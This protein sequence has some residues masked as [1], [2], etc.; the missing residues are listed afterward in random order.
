MDYVVLF[1]ILLIGL[2]RVVIV[3]ECIIF[4]KMVKEGMKKVGEKVSYYHNYKPK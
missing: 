4:C 2:K 1:Y 3:E